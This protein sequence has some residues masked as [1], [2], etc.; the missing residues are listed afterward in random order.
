LIYNHFLNKITIMNSKFLKI[1]ISTFFMMQMALPAPV[2]A[3]QGMQRQKMSLEDR[4]KMQTQMMQQTLSLT[5]EQMPKIEAINLKYAKKIEDFR[6]EGQGQ[7]SADRMGE[8]A[9]MDKDRNT[10][11]QQVL[12][13]EQYKKHIENEEKRR[14]QLRERMQRGRPGGPQGM[15]LTPPPPPQAPNN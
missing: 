11:L 3:Q 1:A 2:M 6:Q 4:A 7:Q 8:L 13:A 10:E 15:P 5:P 12:T 9:K 14:A